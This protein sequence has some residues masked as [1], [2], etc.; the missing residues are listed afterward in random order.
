VFV[1]LFWG[2]RE[3]E[4]TFKDITLRME[5]KEIGHKREMR[6]CFYI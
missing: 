2:K 1:K 4:K 5:N 3:C 6:K